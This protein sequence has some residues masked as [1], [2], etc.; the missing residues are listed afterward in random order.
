MSCLRKL[1][2]VD[3]PENAK[4]HSTH[5]KT[6]LSTAKAATK[7]TGLTC[8]SS[9]HSLGAIICF[10]TADG[11]MFLFVFAPHTFTSSKNNYTQVSKRESSRYY[12]SVT[13]VPLLVLVDEWSKWIEVSCMHSTTPSNTLQ[14]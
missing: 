11:S 3:K 13:T 10:K 8:T 12:I 4:R 9:V 2:K 5:R 14:T 1:E 7:P 6:K